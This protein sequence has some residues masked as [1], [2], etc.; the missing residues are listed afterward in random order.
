M[1]H[2]KND[3]QGTWNSK[4]VQGRPTNKVYQIS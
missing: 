2:T 1:K 4:K 3:T